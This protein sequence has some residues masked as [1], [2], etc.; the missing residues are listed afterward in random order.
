[1]NNNSNATT[2]HCMFY[3]V[4]QRLLLVLI[5]FLPVGCLTIPQSSQKTLDA[6]CIVGMDPNTG[7]RLSLFL[8]L[9]QPDVPH[10]W[11]Q[12][13]AIEV[14]NGDNWLT[15]TSGPLEIDTAKLGKEQIFIGRKIMPTGDYIQIRI[16]TTK[17][18]FIEE[19]KKIPITVTKPFTE[20]VLPA[21]LNMAQGN[22]HSFF[23]D[24]DVNASIKD[25]RM[26]KMVVA[27]TSSQ[28]LPIITNLAYIACPEIDTI[29]IVRT[30]KNMVYGSLGVSG[31]PTY[32][33]TN[34]AT[35]RLYILAADESAVKVI[36]LS[37]NLLLDIIKIPTLIDP[38][39]MALNKDTSRAYILDGRKNLLINLDLQTGN[40]TNQLKIGQHPQYVL[41]M[42]EQ[43][44]L[45]V[46]SAMDQSVY[47][48][49]P[50]N[51]KII[52]SFPV[53][54]PPL[55]LMVWDDLLYITEPEVNTVAIYE[56][57]GRKIIKRFNVGFSPRRLIATSNS[58]YITNF[59][60]GT[61][62]LLIPGQFTASKEIKIGRRPLE[63]AITENHQWLYIGDENSKGLSVV[64][65][66]SNRMNS[67][68][69]LGAKPVGISVIN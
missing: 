69:E 3:T 22:S 57:T 13:S 55:G 31:S 21:P 42:Q 34:L 25:N 64:D 9:R 50:N 28:T 7:G 16:T 19:G 46:S 14:L 5:L 58:I 27:V 45:A 15:I 35:H 23:L 12:I 61:A 33:A 39:H 38:V 41:Y 17:A 32:L 54:S 37:T 43:G 48:V 2:Y 59:L 63:M 62:S 26:D 49:D 20:I 24:W 36:D 65:I 66:T 40:I 29:Y 4:I 11:T 47:L 6:T 56:L 1:M 8:N 18:A 53:S 30:D 52:E 60:D 44:L 67:T 10:I 51:L 68:I